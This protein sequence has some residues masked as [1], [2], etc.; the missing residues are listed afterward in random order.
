[1]TPQNLN[2]Y[3][4]LIPLTAAISFVYTATRYESWPLIWK[5]AIRLAITIFVIM[6]VVAVFLVLLNVLMEWSA[7]TKP[8]D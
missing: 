1:M 7:S 4:F 8:S 3:W 6:A 5:Q 2:V